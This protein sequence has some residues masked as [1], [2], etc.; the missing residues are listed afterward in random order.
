GDAHRL[1]DS[2]EE[3]RVVSKLWIMLQD[4]GHTRGDGGGPRFLNAS[5]GHAQVRRFD[6][7]HHPRRSQD[8]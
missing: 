8:A 4:T 5:H 2:Q 6:Q 1:S 3:L 7:N